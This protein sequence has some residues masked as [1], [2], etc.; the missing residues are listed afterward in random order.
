VEG[1]V[2]QEALLALAAALPAVGVALVGWWWSRRDDRAT[3][4][5]LRDENARLLEA[6][7]LALERPS[8]AGGG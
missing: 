5:A 2:W 8:R 1:A 6:L 3:I 4:R 7:H